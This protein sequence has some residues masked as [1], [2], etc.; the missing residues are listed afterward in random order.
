MH[1]MFFHSAHWTCKNL[2]AIDEVFWYFIYKIQI[3][4]LKITWFEAWFNVCNLS[5]QN[6]MLHAKHAIVIKNKWCKCSLWKV[7]TCDGWFLFSSNVDYMVK[8]RIFIILMSEVSL[9]IMFGIT[10]HFWVYSIIFIESFSIH[11]IRS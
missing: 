9:D 7:V 2:D 1:T 3:K 8:R 10:V 5:I 6:V 4:N 11:F